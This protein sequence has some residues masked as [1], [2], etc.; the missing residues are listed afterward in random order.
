MIFKNLYTI[1]SELPG[2][3]QAGRIYEIKINKGHPVFKAHF[4]GNPVLPG[5]CM[6]Q[7]IK[8]VTEKYSGKKLFM[9]KCFN[10]KFLA[11]VNPEIK[12]VLR[13]EMQIFQEGNTIRVK[14][15]TKFENTIAVKFSAQYRIM[16]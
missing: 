8:E 12:P 6:M 9:E 4:P 2:E 15:L 13:L 7:I 11:L 14:N 16:D 1:I 10:V 5:V 3:D